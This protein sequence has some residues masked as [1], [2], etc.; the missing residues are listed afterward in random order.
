MLQRVHRACTAEDQWGP[1]VNKILIYSNKTTDIENKKMN[2]V[3]E[4][5]TYLDLL[6]CEAG[7][8]HSDPHSGHEHLL[9]ASKKMRGAILL[10]TADGSAQGS[11]AK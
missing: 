11:S 5:V 4:E 1:I 9:A 6:L 3:G 8:E 7:P 10:F 2:L